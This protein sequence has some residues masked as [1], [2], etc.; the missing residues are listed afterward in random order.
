MDIRG[1]ILLMIEI[2]HGPVSTV[3]QHLLGVLYISS[4][5]F[6]IPPLE[7]TPQ[8]PETPIAAK[9]ALIVRHLRLRVSLSTLRR[10]A[11]VEK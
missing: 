10:Q 8:T 11:H 6:C 5:R 3:L 9:L 2:L 1:G 4:C 7:Q